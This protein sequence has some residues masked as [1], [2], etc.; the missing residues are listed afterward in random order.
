MPFK[1]NALTWTGIILSVIWFNLFVGYFLYYRALGP[2]KYFMEATSACDGA[3]QAGNDIAI[4]LDRKEDRVAQQNENRAKWRQC[5]ADIN[6]PYRRRL[7]KI[8]QRIPFVAA[9]G[10]GTVTLGWV[11]AWF[12]ALFARRIRKQFS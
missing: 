5:R 3:L 12:A 11:I 2:N 4:L 1:F 8:Y 7:D 10:L 9:A 6:Q